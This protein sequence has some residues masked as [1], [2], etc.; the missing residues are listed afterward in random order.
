MIF[1]LLLFLPTLLW[2]L[3][4]NRVTASD[5]STQQAVNYWS[6]LTKAQQIEQVKE[7]IAGRNDTP[8]V[9]FPK[10]GYVLEKTGALT[11]FPI[12]PTGQAGMK[13]VIGGYLKYNLKYPS[14]HFKI[15]T[16]SNVLSYAVAAF[17]VGS[18]AGILGTLIL[19]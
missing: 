11:V 2:A 16:R 15:D 8:T 3:S 17:I 19:K 10:W 9:P 13:L 12:Y 7:Y 1:L 14:I 6:A 18:L 4:S 5:I